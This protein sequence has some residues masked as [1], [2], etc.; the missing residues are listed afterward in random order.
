MENNKELTISINNA[1][2]A[3]R[4]TDENGR[5]LLEHLFGKEVFELR[6]VKERIKTFEDAMNE[7][8]IENPLVTLY[9][10]FLKDI[11][12]KDN[13]DAD[14]TAYLK[15]RVIA[16][17]LNE[18]WQPKFTEDECRWFPYFYIY[19]KEQ[20]DSLDEYEK[21]DCRVVGRAYSVANV[22]GGVVCAG[23]VYA[24]SYSYTDYGSRLAFRTEELAEYCGK[25]F[26]DLWIEYL[27]G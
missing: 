23:A 16:A 17:A 13:S 3:Y 18:G 10:S 1:L 26:I 2:N 14:V 22:S 12:E 15:L 7:L 4:N 25:Q 9:D 21:K 27:I 20:Y 11:P 24:W 6:D 8:G 19:T 5:D